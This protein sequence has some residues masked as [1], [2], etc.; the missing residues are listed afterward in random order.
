ME[1][2]TVKPET[3]KKMIRLAV[4][5][6]LILSAAFFAP[7]RTFRYPEAW[8]YIIL[9]LSCAIVVVTYFIRRDPEFLERRM[10]TRE[11]VKEQK[12]IIRLAWIL[13]LPIFVLPGFDRYYGWS[14]VPVYLVVI[15]DILV[16]AGYMIVFRVFRENSF[17][18]RVIEINAGQK[19]IST[20]PYSLVRHP[21]YSGSLLMYWF[22]PIALGSYWA[23]TGSAMLFVMIIFRLLSEEKYLSENLPG[24]REYMSV[25]RYRLVPGVW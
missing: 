12:L 3:R 20:G 25:T 9:I 14:H 21:M 1:K 5:V 16:I 6:I 23:L 11:K 17:A 10:R 7:A 2:I 4:L 19:V 15:S 22:T 8:V 13:F 18:S 24:Y